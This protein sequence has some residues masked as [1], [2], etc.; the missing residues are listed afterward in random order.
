[1]NKLE[2]SS[3]IAANIRRHRKALKMSIGSLAERA[4]LGDDY[5]GHIERGAKVPSLEVLGK[6]ATGLGVGIEALVR[7]VTP[8]RPGPVNRR[9]QNF[10]RGLTEGQKG[11]ALAILTKLRRPER[12]RALRV[13]LGA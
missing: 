3:K 13:A 12:V 11:D 10:L 6:I 1:M 9:L 2:L 8:E 4:E 5:L 7:Q